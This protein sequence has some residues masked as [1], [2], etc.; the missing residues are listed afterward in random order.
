MKGGAKLVPEIK[1]KAAERDTEL[2]LP[3][4]F[5]SSSKFCKDGQINENDLSTGVPEG[6]GVP[7]SFL[8]HT[9]KAFVSTTLDPTFMRVVGSYNNEWV[10]LAAS[11]T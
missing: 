7:E 2:T 6:T 8:S 10:A 1:E 4:D 3:V 5:A 9:D 11:G